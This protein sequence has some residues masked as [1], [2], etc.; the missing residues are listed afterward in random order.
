MRYLLFSDND[1][2]AKDPATS[3]LINPSPDP[4]SS[5]FTLPCT[6]DPKLHRST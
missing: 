6:D 4:I 5:A 3:P 1:I 2:D